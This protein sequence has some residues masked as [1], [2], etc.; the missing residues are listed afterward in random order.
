MFSRILIVGLVAG[1]IAGLVLAAVQHVKITPLI[2][3][4]EV[5]EDEAAAHAHTHDGAAAAGGAAEAHEHE[6]AWE[7]RAGAERTAFT[8][9]ADLIVA[10]GFGLV[11]SGSLAVRHA[12]AGHVPD[13]SEGLLWGFAGF[14]AFSLAPALGLPPQPPGMVAAA[15][16]SRQAWWIGT[17]IATCAGLGLMVFCRHW[18]LR[19]AG[20]VLLILPH[21]IGAPVRPPGDDAVTADIAARFVAASLVT[22]AVF[23]SVLGAVSGWLYA[24]LEKRNALLSPRPQQ[25]G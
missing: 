1:F 15:I 6:T 3:A 11:L 14:A 7:P 25:I 22:S 24:A 20:L 5:Y 17:A 21:L 9:L 23:W 12:V 19:A 8:F 16:Y 13:G 4:A 10:V 18:A 2:T